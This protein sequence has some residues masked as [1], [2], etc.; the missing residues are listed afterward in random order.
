MQPERVERAASG[1]PG[2]AVVK[3]ILRGL[4][5]VPSLDGARASDPEELADILFDQVERIPGNQV[6][7][8]LAVLLG[9]R[10][11]EM[12]RELCLREHLH[13]DAAGIADEVIVALFVGCLEG[14]RQRPLASWA[15]SVLRYVAERARS[16]RGLVVPALA[17][18]ATR[19][20][21]V[22]HTMSWTL[23]R[24]PHE[25]RR[26]AWLAWHERLAVGEVARITGIHQERLEFILEQIVERVREEME[27]LAAQG[28]KQEEGMEE[29]PLRLDG[30]EAEDA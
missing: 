19:Q 13:L 3:G 24:L 20:E 27:R 10:L 29:G 28:A 1:P 26:V 16:D 18:D 23:N 21:F 2:I 15:E 6:L 7:Y 4:D 9:E 22:Q 11:N 8:G 12:A 25:A 14:T 5:G 30:E 17:R